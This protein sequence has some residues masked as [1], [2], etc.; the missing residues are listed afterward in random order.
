MVETVTSQDAGQSTLVGDGATIDL[1]TQLPSQSRG[2]L[3]KIT[4][5]GLAKRVDD[6]SGQTVDG[7][8]M[9]TP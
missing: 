6:D 1:A 4:D 7:S 3:S 8:V 2:A 9:G 5:F